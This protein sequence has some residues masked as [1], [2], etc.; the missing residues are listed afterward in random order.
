MDPVLGSFLG[1]I[2]LLQ[3]ATL[4]YLWQTSSRIDEVV[5]QFNRR[6]DEVVVQLNRRIDEVAAELNLRIDKVVGQIHD[7]G[8]E[9]NHKIDDL[10]RR[11]GEAEQRVARLEGGRR[12]TNR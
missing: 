4:T 1:L 12:A 7:T 2:T 3:I 11:F 10:A 6:I 5:V 9:T 8:R